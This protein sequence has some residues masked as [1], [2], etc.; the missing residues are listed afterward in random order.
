MPPFPPDCGGKRLDMASRGKPGETRRPVSRLYLVIP[1]EAGGSADLLAQVLGAAAFSTALLRLPKFG[2]SGEGEVWVCAIDAG[3]T[4]ASKRSE[5]NDLRSNIG[6][7]VADQLQIHYTPDGKSSRTQYLRSL[8]RS[9][10][11]RLLGNLR[12]ARVGRCT[13]SRPFGDQTS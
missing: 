13:M 1:H 8:T 11:R 6:T 9:S 12:V 10:R 4:S 7:P 5:I 2:G 3:T